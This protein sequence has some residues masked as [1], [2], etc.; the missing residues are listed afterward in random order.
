[1]NTKQT[2]ESVIHTI[3]PIYNEHS[4]ILMLGTMP[5]P[6][7]REVGFYYGH[8]R[9][10]FWPVLAD[11]FEEAYPVETKDKIDFALRH[12]IAIWDVLR[13]CTI[14]GASDSSI[15]DAV[16]ND[17]SL[18]FDHANIEA[19]FATGQ[20]AASLYRTFWDQ[21]SAH[22]IITLPSTSPANCRVSYEALLE[23][24]RQILTYLK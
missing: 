20:K 12:R 15:Q 23:E 11:V 1:M 17:L 18:I 2:A 22:R 5:S 6:K 21:K 14:K 19:V 7:S 4:R 3:E 9:N 8:P 13:S 16:P 10:R 24:Y